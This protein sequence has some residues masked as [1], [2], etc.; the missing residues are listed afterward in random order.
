MKGGG[1]T[2]QCYATKLLHQDPTVVCST[3][4]CS[5]LQP[6]Q[7]VFASLEGNSD[8]EV[9]PKVCPLNSSVILRV[10][11]ISMK[12]G[13]LIQGPSVG[14]IHCGIYHKHG[15]KFDMVGMLCDHGPCWG[16]HIVKCYIKILF[17]ALPADF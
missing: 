11:R 12:T 17:L 1:T 2:L 16:I 15:I 13:R 8:L 10:Y 14:W 7:L 3:L 5:Y 9:L 6:S 4:S